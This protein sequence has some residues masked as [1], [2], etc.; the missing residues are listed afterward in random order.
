MVKAFV[1]S[2][3]KDMREI[4]KQLDTY[5]HKVG[6]EPVLSEFGGVFYDPDLH[7]HQ[8]RRKGD[9]M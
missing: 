1:S 7:T 3:C 9:A 5:L 2:T 8:L 4:R 6:V